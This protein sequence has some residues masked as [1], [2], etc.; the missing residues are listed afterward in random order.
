VIARRAAL[1][2]LL[3][4]SLSLSILAC[5]G[6]EPASAPTAPQPLAAPLVASVAAPPSAP[7]APASSA[8]EPEPKPPAAAVVV[9]AG[10]AFPPPSFAAP[11]AKTAKDGDGVWAPL[12]ADAA[13]KPPLLV[14]TTVHPDASDHA[15][16]AAIVAIDR[17]R[18][19]LR[20]LAGTAEPKSTSV[21]IERRPGVIP[22]AEH[23]DLL[24]VFNGGFMAKHGGWGMRIG[25]DTFLP[26]KE[27][28]CTVAFVNDGSLRIRSWTTLAPAAATI[29]AY[30]QTPPCLIEQGVVNPVL[31]ADPKTRRWGSSETGDTT[32]RRSAL[33]LDASG[34]TLFY[35]LGE[36]ITPRGL[37]AAMRAAGAVDVAELDVNWSYTRFLLYAPGKPGEAPEVSETLVPKIKH[38]TK[39]YVVK[40]SD[41]DFF[42]LLRRR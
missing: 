33:G 12:V 3:P 40:P 5:G 16:Y 18:V 11:E 25:A 26:P 9:D 22:A 6:A 13:G 1:A 34:K 39:G 35:G 28:A 42:Y 8:R 30:R 10:P 32:I 24:A 2:A 21:P 15:M 36:W 7:T 29:T 23:A 20:F 37:A 38:P 41:R 31:D 17:R 14:R 19:D 4:L 27:E